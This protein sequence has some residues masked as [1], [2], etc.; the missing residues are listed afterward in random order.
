MHLLEDSIPLADDMHFRQQLVYVHC[1]M[2]HQLHDYDSQA[3]TTPNIQQHSA[4]SHRIAIDER[5][6]K[7]PENE[8][9]YLI[10]KTLD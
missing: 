2:D 1:Y 9:F 4:Q 5:H 7:P 3:G 6:L 10:K 8:G